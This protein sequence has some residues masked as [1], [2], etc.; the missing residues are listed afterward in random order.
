VVTLCNALLDGYRMTQKAGRKKVSDGSGGE[1]QRGREEC[2]QTPDELYAFVSSELERLATA[3]YREGAAAFFQGSVRLHGVRAAQLVPLEQQVYR[4]AKRWPRAQFNTFCNRLW[5]TGMLEEGAMVCH[6]YRRFQRT[7][8]ACEFR[9]FESWIDRYVSNW[10]HCDGVASWLLAAAIGNHPEL[11]E[12]LMTWTASRNRWKRRAAAVALLQ[13]AKNGRHTSFILRVASA[14]MPDADDMVQKGV[15]WLLKET[16]P[17]QKAA[18][19]EFL[20][21]WQPQTSRVVVRYACEKMTPQDR[22]RFF[23]K[24]AKVGAS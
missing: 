4:V 1:G 11:M 5:K 14:L 17:K 13:E 10:A 7:C 24:A 20:E 15:G 12:Q 21:R 18:V 16:Y 2:V 8:G 6:V 9:L 3:E 23:A 19:V 22:A